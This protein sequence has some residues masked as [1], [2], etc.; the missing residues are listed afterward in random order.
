ME[1]DLTKEEKANRLVFSS[2]NALEE[3]D[4][5]GLWSVENAII[6]AYFTN[7]NSKIL[8][9][10][11]GLGRTTQPLYEKG[12]QVTGIDTSQPMIKKAKIKYPD[13]DFR[14]GDACDLNFTDEAFNYVLFSFNGI[15]DIHPKEKR[16]RALR[17]INR[18]LKVKG[19][20][21]F[22]AH[23]SWS[24]ESW[25]TLRSMLISKNLTSWSDLLKYLLRPYY[26]WDPT[27]SG[28]VFS[29]YTNPL[30]Q[31]KQLNSA[32]FQC[33]KIVGS[34]RKNIY[35]DSWPYYVAQKRKTIPAKFRRSNK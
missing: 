22:S 28:K 9:I 18:V 29:Y 20:F 31:K 27:D 2:Q 35:I 1:N 24:K 4:K 23:N 12:F 21:V 17:E 11:C 26:K 33:I 15:D 8:D 13:I 6:D 3:Y 7:K 32:G 5:I 25:S 30:N 19:L 14:V 10:G 34:R 16:I